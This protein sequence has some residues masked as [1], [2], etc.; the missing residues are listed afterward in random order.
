MYRKL[1]DPSMD[2]NAS[3]KA[4]YEA[5]ETKTIKG[6]VVL[7]KKNFLDLTD[8]KDAVVDQ[9]DE[10][11]GHKVSLQLI[12]AVNTDVGMI[13]FSSFFESYTLAI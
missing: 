10:I 12:S 13:Y 7:M 8:A 6:T 1:S 3:K 9:I 2:E 5:G 11:L 4:R